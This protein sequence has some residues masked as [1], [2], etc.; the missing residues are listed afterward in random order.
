VAIYAA[1]LAVGRLLLTAIHWYSTRNERLLDEPQDPATMRF[2][3]VRGLTTPA[4]FLL[5]IAI[6]FFSVR[7]AIWT[8]F[9]MIAVDD[10]L[11]IHRR[12]R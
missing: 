5:S 2:F 6:S 11:V 12:F 8:W 1:T 3:L 9:A 7:T 10:A 4:I